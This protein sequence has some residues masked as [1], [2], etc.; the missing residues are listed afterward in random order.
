MADLRKMTMGEVAEIADIPKETARSRLKGS[1]GFVN[2]YG[3][4]RFDVAMTARV[5][6]HAQ[7]LRFYGQ[8][9][10]AFNVADFVGGS[11]ENISEIPPH[12]LKRKGML[13]D[14]FLIFRQTY[15]PPYPLPIKPIWSQEWC[16]SKD[17][18]LRMLGVFA[19]ESYLGVEGAGF[20][21][22]NVGTL[23]DW[24]LDRVFDLQGIDGSEATVP[25]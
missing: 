6:V 17:E 3:W 9:E 20:F 19:R 14:N 18:A 21:V 5:A 11:L 16:K 10:I 2:T 23:T 13:K 15:A 12:V 1:L 25:Q 22:V 4:A 24:A 8:P 7:A